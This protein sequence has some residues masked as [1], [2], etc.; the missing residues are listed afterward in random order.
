MTTIDPDDGNEMHIFKLQVVDPS[1]D[2][3]VRDGEASKPLTPPM[4]IKRLQSV[5]PL[6]DDRLL[7]EPATEPKVDDQDQVNVEIFPLKMAM[8]FR[9]DYDLS[10]E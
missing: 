7:Y 5:L 3:G 6:N 1:N 10:S 9:N 8:A 4:S 2:N